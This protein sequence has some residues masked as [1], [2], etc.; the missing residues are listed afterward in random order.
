[1]RP[2]KCGRHLIE[3]LVPVRDEGPHLNSPG[4]EQPQGAPVRRGTAVGLESS[5]G[6]DR[7]EHRRLEKLHVVQH[8]EVDASMPMTVPAKA[9]G[10]V[11]AVV[12]ARARARTAVD[13]RIPKMLSPKDAARLWSEF[14]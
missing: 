3:R 7:R 4:F 2:P 9:V 5:R 8:A 10:G 1:M 14:Q 13:R 12:T 11:N 6:P